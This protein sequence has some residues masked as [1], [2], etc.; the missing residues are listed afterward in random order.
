MSSLACENDVIKNYRVLLKRKK[1]HVFNQPCARLHEI[2]L[3]LAFLYSMAR[4]T[5]VFEL[6]IFVSDAGLHVEGGGTDGMRPKSK[7]KYS[8][9]E[10]YTKASPLSFL[11]R[12]EV[13]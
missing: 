9:K 12:L 13:L 10:F 6:L 2:V 5:H 7:D 8:S 3:R 11:R 4:K 1:K